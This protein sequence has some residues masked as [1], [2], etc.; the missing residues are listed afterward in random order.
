MGMQWNALIPEQRFAFAG[1][2]QQIVQTVFVLVY[3][4]SH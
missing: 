4:R 2:G 1:S 3:F